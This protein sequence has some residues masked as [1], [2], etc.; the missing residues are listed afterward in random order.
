MNIF[1]SFIF[2][3]IAGIINGSFAIPTKYT[4]RWN[5]ENIWLQYAIWAFLILPWA[6]ILILA[7]QVLKV[8]VASP[9]H[10]LAI[11]IIGGFLFGAGQIG[12]AF[13]MK[14]IGIGLSFVI[15]LGLSMGLGFFLPLV[16]QHPH[17]ILTSFGLIT[18]L[19]TLLAV[20]GLIVSTYAGKLRDQERQKKESAS[21]SG[22]GLKKFY[23][24]GVF[25]AVI[26]GLFSA[27]QNFS[28]SLTVPMQQIALHMGASRLGAAN[29]MWPGFL[30]FS[31]LPYAY[32]MIFLLK[33]NKSFSYYHR[34]G[35]TK[36]YGFAF[37]MGLF[38]FG[39]LIFYSKASQLIGSL[40]PVI[41]WPMF[42]V[43]IILTS[44]FL[45]WRHKEWEGC[46]SKAKYTIW[47]GLILLILSVLVLGYSSRI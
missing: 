44:N 16:V 43:L 15:C 3:L 21:S 27:G 7:P 32:Y 20:S 45:G 18:L 30:F 47:I 22:K 29:I 24:I 9:P 4:D 38:W 14:L 12:F 5:F 13:A 8:Y 1:I 26:A 2:I 34:S 42:M 39:S 46:G 10:L 17:E 37:I 28:F 11:M 33:K 41:G 19:G 35:T 31:F 23:A 36:Y 40:G 6:A 25:L